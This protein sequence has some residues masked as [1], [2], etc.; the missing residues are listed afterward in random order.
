MAWASEL[1][2]RIA[3]LRRD[4]F[5]RQEDLEIRERFILISPDGTRYSVTVANNGALIT[6]AV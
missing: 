4:A 1:T 3:D 6:T 5:R 2:R